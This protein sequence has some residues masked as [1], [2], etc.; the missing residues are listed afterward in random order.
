MP[1]DNFFDRKQ[2]LEI[3]EKRVSGFKHGYRQNLA[4][5]GDELVGKTSLIFEF[6]NKFCDNN[7]IIMYLEVRPESLTLF[8]RRFIGVL[9][10][11]FLV[12]S[13]LPLEENL[14]FLM[15]KAQRF[16]PH[17]VEKIKSILAAVSGRK[18]NNVFHD[19]LTL[20]DAI[21]QETGKSCVIV[22][23]EFH[24]LENMGIKNL[25]REWS[26]LLI[27]QKSTMYIIAS[28]LK[29]KTKLIL[30]K[31]LSL[32]FGNFELIS[33]EP[34]DIKTSEEYLRRK[35][36]GFSL[37]A[38]LK[39]FLVHF[40]GGFPL[41]LELITDAL[42]KSSQIRLAETLEGLLFDVSGI[43]NQRFS[44]Y[45]KRFLDS[46]HSQDYLS[47]LYLIASGHNKIRDISHILGKTKKEAVLRINRLLELD[48]VN[49][50]GDFL[51][52]GDRVFGFWMKFVYQEKMHSLTFDAKNQKALFR[53]NIEGL[54]QDFLCDARKPLAERMT[55][56]LRLFEDET[57]Q[58]EKKR[59]RLN[60]FREIKPLEFN[61]RNLKDGLIGRSTDSLWI[62]AF[63]P[64]QLNEEDISEFAKECKKYRHKMQRKIIITF[65][66]IEINA[67]LRAM[68]EKI[69]T[70]DLNNLNQIFDL[71]Y[72][73][74][75]IA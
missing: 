75:V 58:I 4:I 70:W 65:K 33:V 29:F 41:Y 63:K 61:Y 24:N 6:L 3:L 66:D 56:L 30:S 23:D 45:I 53:N 38:G 37:E 40:T 26:R 7:I 54:I 9:L 1:K 69:L 11:N 25:Y 12:N 14:D 27:T 64:D 32:L 73:P 43:L 16:I 18:K 49:R 10:Y 15:K 72:K 60:H 22:L 50:S 46:P 39:N 47:I 13:G 19:L 48:A 74:R 35:L 57:I 71:F 51:K 42:L 44:N 5:T 2:Y 52:I 36:A 8:T 62:M 68:E 31:N 55:E 67:R 59:L 34:F 20:C 17:T 21:N 28:S